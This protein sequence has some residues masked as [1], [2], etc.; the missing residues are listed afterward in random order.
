MAYA[1]QPHLAIRDQAFRHPL[2]GSFHETAGVPMGFSGG[3]QDGVLL[4]HTPSADVPAMDAPNTAY[5]LPMECTQLPSSLRRKSIC[6]QA[7]ALVI[8][9]DLLL[10][11]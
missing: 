2:C 5:P 4:M 8:E 6:A 9:R 1:S 11:V 10:A 7:R 3:N